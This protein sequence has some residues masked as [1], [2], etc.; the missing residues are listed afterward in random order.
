MKKATSCLI[1][2]NLLNL[3]YYENRNNML[4]SFDNIINSYCACTKSKIKNEINYGLILRILKQSMIRDMGF[5]NLLVYQ[6]IKNDSGH[7]MD[8]NLNNAE[9]FERFL[10]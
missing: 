6:G 5:L 3:V 1:A 9:F 4:V 10:S 8:L 2:N 7:L